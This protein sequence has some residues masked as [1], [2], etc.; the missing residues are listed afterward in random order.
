M[1]V[2]ATVTGTLDLDRGDAKL[3]AKASPGEV[4]DTMRFQAEDMKAEIG[5][6]A[7][8]KAL[9]DKVKGLLDKIKRQSADTKKS[10]G[11]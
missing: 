10:E 11:E 3:L 6:Q 1:K 2:R 9:K 4:L 8:V 5:E 7:A